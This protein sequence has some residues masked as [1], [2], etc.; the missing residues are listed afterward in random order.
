MKQKP[1]KAGNPGFAGF[2]RVGTDVA[3]IK[4]T[5]LEICLKILEEVSKTI[6]GFVLSKS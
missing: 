3:I 1:R 4:A 5:R 2:F 6:I